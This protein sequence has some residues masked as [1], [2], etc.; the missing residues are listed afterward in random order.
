MNIVTQAQTA[1]KTS[2]RTMTVH[3]VL[4]GDEVLVVLEADPLG[5]LPEL[6]GAAELLERQD[7]LAAER[8][9]HAD[10]EHQDRRDDAGGTGRA[11]GSGVVRS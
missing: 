9:A 11:C 10:D 1:Q 7:Q 6:L 8:V 2:D 5:G 4:V 3:I